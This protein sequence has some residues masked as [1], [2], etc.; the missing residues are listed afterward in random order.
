MNVKKIVLIIISLAIILI[1]IFAWQWYYKV[2]KQPLVKL[3]RNYTILYIP[4]HSNYQNVVELLYKQNI[5][6]DTSLFNQFAGLKNYPERVKP[7]RYKIEN[8]LSAN[9]LINKLRSGNQLPV[10]LTFNNIRFLPKLAGI[11]GNKLE[12]DSAELMELLKDPVFLE[13]YNLE[14][15]TIISL[16]LPNTYEFFWNTNAV[17]FMDRMKKE[18]DK[19]WNQERVNKAT[20]I[21]L[22][23]LKVNILASIIQEETNKKDEMSRMAGVLIN[24]LNRGMKLEADPTARFAHGD[25]SI[26]R[27]LK[28]YTKIESP[29]N[30]YWVTGL[31][32]GPITMAEPSTIDA[33]LHYEKHH[34]LFYCAKADGSGY[35]AFARTNSQH[36]RNARAYRN[37]TY[38][39]R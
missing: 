29:Y 5:I 17:E 34:Y 10:K 27:V 2:F 28:E 22:N 8:G 39:R 12:L 15:R 4:T 25:F 38:G 18:H 26:N 32:T 37:K 14:P 13:K 20:A 19:F 23:P 31:P 3:D 1:G 7:G 11:V 9:A 16:F 6:K 21:G 24:R 36:N 33:V 35:H 30:T